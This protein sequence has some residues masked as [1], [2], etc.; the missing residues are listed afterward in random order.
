ML[1]S[2]VNLSVMCAAGVNIVLH[3]LTFL[4]T[5]PCFLSVVYSCYFVVWWKAWSLSALQCL[6]LPISSYSFASSS[7]CVCLKYLLFV[8]SLPSHLLSFISPFSTTVLSLDLHLFF[9]STSWILY[10][11]SCICDCSWLRCPTCFFQRHKS[12]W[13]SLTFLSKS[14]YLFPLCN[15]II[16][17]VDYGSPS[18]L[19][20]VDL[21]KQLWG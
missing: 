14:L 15:C 12:N 4:L 6:T 10:L 21:H 19:F 8:L 9:F 18:C 13:F 11:H 2:C 1:F 5:W 7:Q 20:L 16:M 3:C 17:I